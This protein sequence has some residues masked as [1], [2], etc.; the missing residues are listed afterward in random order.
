MV[1]TK[2][3]KP[4]WI[5]DFQYPD[6]RMVDTLIVDTIPGFNYAHAVVPS[7]G[8]TFTPRIYGMYTFRE[9]SRIEAIR[10]VMS[11]SASFS[12]VPDM[13]GVVPNYYQEV[14]VDSTGRTRTYPLY[15]ESVFRVPV[16]SGRSGLDHSRLKGP[17]S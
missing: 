12:M 8:L 6:G 15:D 4:Q 7:V 2:S 3:I 17:M 13:S 11:P 10:H 14:Q 9:K 16:P 5:E 1:F